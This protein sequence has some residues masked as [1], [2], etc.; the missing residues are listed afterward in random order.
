MQNRSAL[1]GTASQ[2]LFQTRARQLK[3]S[4]VADGIFLACPYPR[5]PI[6]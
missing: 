6:V 4:R 1:V 5:I 3:M 2:K